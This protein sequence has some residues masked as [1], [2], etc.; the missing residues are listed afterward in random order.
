MNLEVVAK[1]LKELGHPIRLTIYKSVVKAGYQ[2]IAVGG[3]Q[4][5]L[6]IPGSTLSHHIS[7]LASAGLISQ[8]REGR[9][10]FCV[11][12]Y[13]CLEDVIDFLQDECCVNEQ[14]N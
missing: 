2:G 12:E 10:L 5:E 13:E 3:L 6:G 9:T 14:C 1:A 8:R 11:A 4:E 7:S